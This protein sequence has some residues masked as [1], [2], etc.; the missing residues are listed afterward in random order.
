MPVQSMWDSDC[1]NNFLYRIF[2]IIVI[3]K[4]NTREKVQ[5]KNMPCTKY[6]TTDGIFG[7]NLL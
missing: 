5:N 1:N 7:D 4:L 2:E 3:F 6:L